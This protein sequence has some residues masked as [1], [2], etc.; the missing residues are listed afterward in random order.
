[1]PNFFRPLDGDGLMLVGITTEPTFEPTPP[2]RSGLDPVSKDSA[3]RSL[4]VRHRRR[5]IA[6]QQPLRPPPA[7]LAPEPPADVLERHV[8]PPPVA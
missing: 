1:M 4:A 2:S 3:P 6:H 5:M 8:P 7:L